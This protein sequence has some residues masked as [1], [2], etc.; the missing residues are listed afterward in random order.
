MTPEPVICFQLTAAEFL[1]LCNLARDSLHDVPDKYAKRVLLD[2]LA[3]E[4][5]KARRKLR[6]NHVRGLHYDKITPR[7]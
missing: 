7:S 5:A 6:R 4:A 2:H 3:L 1:Q